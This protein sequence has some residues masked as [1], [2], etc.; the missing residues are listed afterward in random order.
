MNTV[1]SRMMILPVILLRKM[2]AHLFLCVQI[3]ASS[4]EHILCIG[5]G[6]CSMVSQ[7]SMLHGESDEHAPRTGQKYMLH[8]LSDKYAP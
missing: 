2:K 8:R 6:A 1:T 4:Q 7:L 3:D 5:G